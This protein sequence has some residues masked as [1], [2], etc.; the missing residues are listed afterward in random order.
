M[1]KYATNKAKSS[2]RLKEDFY[3]RLRNSISMT[4]IFEED[5]K[6]STLEKYLIKRAKMK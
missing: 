6:E 2:S 3:D 5:F 1:A 4:E